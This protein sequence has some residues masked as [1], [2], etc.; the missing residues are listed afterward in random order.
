[1]DS[2]IYACGRCG[3]VDVKLW[4]PYQSFTIN[5][6]CTDCLGVVASI[7]VLEVEQGFVLREQHP[8]WPIHLALG[9]PAWCPAVPTDD[10][11]GFWGYTS[12]PIERLIWWFELPTRRRF[13][14]EPETCGARH[15]T[16]PS[17]IPCNAHEPGMHVSVTGCAGGTV[18]WSTEE[19]PCP[20]RRHEGGVLKYIGQGAYACDLNHIYDQDDPVLQVVRLQ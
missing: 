13:D 17:V 2:D 16:N 4:R 3:E 9:S 7:S 1:M 10:P 12:I 5:L 11:G 15:P 20:D 19:R 18:T 8:D 14:G 6:L